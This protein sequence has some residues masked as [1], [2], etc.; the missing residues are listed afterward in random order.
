MSFVAYKK[1]GDSGPRDTQR[2]VT[3]QGSSGERRRAGRSETGMVLGG[4][5]FADRL[6]SALRVGLPGDMVTGRCSAEGT[7]L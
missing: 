6:S 3:C 1:N 7:R 4:A 2:M 5:T